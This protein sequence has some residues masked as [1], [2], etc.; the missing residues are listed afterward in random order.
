MAAKRANFSGRIW[1]WLAATSF[2][3]KKG[4]TIYSLNLLP[5]GG[6]VRL[7]GEEASVAKDKERAFS[8]KD[9]NAD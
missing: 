5:F 3:I 6:F 4:E 9:K 2:G 8:H 7:Y 1:L